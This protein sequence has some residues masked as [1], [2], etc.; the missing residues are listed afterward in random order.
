MHSFQGKE[1]PVCAEIMGDVN[2]D[3][4]ADARDASAILKAYTMLSA[5]CETDIDPVL[6]DYDFSGSI[7]AVDAS[8]VLRDYAEGS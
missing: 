4:I 8:K 3:S 5:G 7:T 6:A 1:L 2:G